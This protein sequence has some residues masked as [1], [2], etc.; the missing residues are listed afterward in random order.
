[1]SQSPSTAAEGALS[2]GALAFIPSLLQTH[3]DVSLAT[4]GGIAAF[5]AVGGFLYAWNDFFF[6]LILTRTDA[7]TAP[8]AVVNFM[9]YEGWEW[10][11]I[12]AGGSLVMA[13]VLIFSMMVRRYLVS[14]LTAGA[15]KG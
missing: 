5:Y 1:M 14:G 9:N 12:A 3:H 15:V 13:P 10:G 6:A 11:K 8:V 7:R 2:A 4:A